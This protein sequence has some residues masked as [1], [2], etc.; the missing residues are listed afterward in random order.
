M[1][2]EKEMAEAMELAKKSAIAEFKAFEE[3]WEAL[4]LEASRIYSEGFDLC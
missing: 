4:T 2:K 3:Y 1:G